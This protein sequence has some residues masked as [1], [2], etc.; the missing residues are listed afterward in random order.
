MILGRGIKVLFASHNWRLNAGV[1]V[2]Q[3]PESTVPVGLVDFTAE[4]RP[5][6]LVHGEG[7]GQ[8]NDLVQGGEEELV[9]ASLVIAHIILQQANLLEMFG[10]RYGQGEHITDSFVETGIGTSAIDEGLVLILQE[11]L[12]V[13]Q[14]VMHG[15]ELILCDPGALLDAHIVG[16]IKVPGAGMANQITT[17]GG[18]FNDR[19]VPEVP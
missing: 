17:I 18:L 12:N 2:P 19:L 14:F 3:L 8:E 1:L 9:D 11:I 7:E 10:C 5:A 16:E 15:E 6:I 13:S 4:Q